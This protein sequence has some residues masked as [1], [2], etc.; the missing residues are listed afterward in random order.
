MLGHDATGLTTEQVQAQ[1]RRFGFNDIVVETANP[2]I[3][4]VAESFQEPMIWFLVGTS[5]L[6]GLLGQSTEAL[7]LLFAVVPLLAMGLV[8]HRRTAASTAGL[9]SRLA[10][11]ALILRDGEWRQL[12]SRDVVPGDLVKAHPG[13]YF[14]ADG[15][16]IGG[17]GLQVDESTLTG[18]SL[19]V[20]K[21]VWRSTPG[22]TIAVPLNQA[23]AGTRLLTGHATLKV[24]TIGQETRYGRIVASVRDTAVQSTPLQ[25][26]IAEMVKIL[27]IA[28]LFLCIL[29][30]GLRWWQGHGW[31]DALISAVTLAVAAIPEEF[32]V[33]YTFMLG[34]GVYRLARKMALVRRAAA[35]ENIGRTTCIVSDKTGTMTLGE[36]VFAGV[37]ASA[38][39]TPEEVLTVA[40]LAARPDSGDPMD[41]ALHVACKAPLTGHKVADFPFTEARRRETSICSLGSQTVAVTKGAP[42]TLWA[43]CA[44]S[45]EEQAYW[46]AQVDVLAEQGHKVIG[47]AR[48]MVTSRLKCPCTAR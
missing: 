46:Q 27:L 43:V 4:V 33:V 18:E 2:W 15:V 9:A 41:Q 21:A 7:T 45:Q 24:E 34:L 16:L 23:V 40:T 20:A 47:C 37:K 8:L 36:L 6:F 31:V 11:T 3:T 48:K 35:V 10:S 28:A 17:E 29:L 25:K 1:R 12:P 39:C 13:D 19:P 26:A 44:L 22:M 42:E 38:H 5:L 32:P 14:P 30:G